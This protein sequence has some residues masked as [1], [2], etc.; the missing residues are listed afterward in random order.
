[1]WLSN[2]I[3]QEETLHSL[4]F[5]MSKYHL[6]NAYRARLNSPVYEDYVNYQ[7]NLATG[8][9]RTLEYEEFVE[10]LKGALKKLPQSQRRVIKMSKLEQLGNKEIAARLGLSEQTVKHQ[11]SLGLKALHKELECILS[12]LI[13]LFIV[14]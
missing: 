2:C 5:K 1:M 8:E 4:L 3:R 13:L 6:I 11:L 12:W 7:N 10:Q 14:N 9:E